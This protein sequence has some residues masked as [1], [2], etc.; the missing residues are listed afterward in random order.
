MCKKKTKYRKKSQQKIFKEK[1]DKTIQT[2]VKQHL[3]L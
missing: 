1:R 2:P 3:A